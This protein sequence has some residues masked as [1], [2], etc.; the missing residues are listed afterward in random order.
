MQALSDMQRSLTYQNALTGFVYLLLFIV[1]EG[2]TSIYLLLPPLLG[3]LFFH[4][5]RSMKLQRPGY[6]LLVIV[7]LL[8]YETEKGYLLFSTLVYF[9]FLH[10]F[11][12]PKL[13]QSIHCTWCLNLI[14][15][16]LAYIGFWLFAVLLHQML[17]QPLPSID[18]HIIYYIII[19]FFLVSIL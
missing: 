17:W 9:A 4:F 8:V 7:M 3:V 2:V 18:W 16:I 11:V 6:L 19:E 1:Y 13:E 10:R 12:I 14:Y 5:L 15:V